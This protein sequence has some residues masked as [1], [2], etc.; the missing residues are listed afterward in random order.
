M[1]SRVRSNADDV[2]VTALAWPSVVPI[3][4]DEW[5]TLRGWT[6]EDADAVLAACQDEETQRWMDVPVPFLPEHA[7]DFVEAHSRRQWSSQQGAPFAIA[8][9]DNDQVL[10]SCGLVGVTATQLVA[11][12][13]YAVA[14]WARGRKV[15]QR[16]ARLL[17]DWAMTEVGL[18]RLEFYIEPSNSASR[19]VATRLGGQF[20]G[21]LRSKAVIRGTRRDM[22]LYALV[23]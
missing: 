7:A 5:V 14:P 3:L 2:L 23:K 21:I 8:A 1:A 11:E 19:A 9:V 6:A 4:T 16:A 12:V 17:C 13:V 15:A 18:A 20:E 10:G 22:A